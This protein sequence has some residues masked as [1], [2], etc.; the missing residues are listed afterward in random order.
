M[1]KACRE[2]RSAYLTRA[3]R[4]LI[5]LLGAFVLSGCETAKPVTDLIPV[6]HYRPTNIYLRSD[7]T[8]SLVK[9]VA[10]LPLTIVKGPAELETGAHALEPLLHAELE[11]GK[12]FELYLVT[13]QQ[14]REWTG[15]SSW[16]A[17]DPLPKEFFTHLHERT[18]CDG[19]LF[20]E[21]TRYQ[22]YE[23]VAVGWKFTLLEIA[24]R[25]IYWSAD[26]VFDGGDPHVSSAARA[27]YSQHVGGQVTATDS[28]IIAASPGLFGQYSLAALISTIPDNKAG[29]FGLSPR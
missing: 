25:Q 16:R 13:A 11:K 3:A 1:K 4:G 23:P 10:V 20:S 21:L 9:R 5:A 19:V 14:L 17:E 2:R 8:N 18:A 29:I 22:P 7:W 27:Y 6:S 26:E 28:S 15:Q 24:D 12:H